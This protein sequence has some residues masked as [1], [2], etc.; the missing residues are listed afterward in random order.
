VWTAAGLVAFAL[1]EL[2]RSPDPPLLAWDEAGRYVTAGVILAAVAYQLTSV[3]RACLVRCRSP[4]TFLAEGWRNGLDLLSACRRSR[5][6]IQ[7]AASPNEAAALEDAASGSHRSRCFSST[8]TERP[9][10][11]KP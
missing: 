8:Y 6:R 9:A 1:F 11:R 7:S 4:R 3:K 2:V 5:V 10:G